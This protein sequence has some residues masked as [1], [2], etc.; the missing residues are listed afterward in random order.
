VAQRVRD[1]LL[2][3][4]G[5]S[6]DAESDLHQLA[7]ELQRF[8]GITA[9][10]D[11]DIQTAAAER[12]LKSATD[13]VKAFG[14][15]SEEAKVDLQTRAAQVKLDGL[16]RNLENLQKKE[17]SPKVDLAIGA[18]VAKIERVE[19]QLDKLDR[20]RVDIDIDVDR[21]GR[22]GGIAGAAVGAA[23]G[24]ASGISTAA[25]GL[26]EVVAAAT[27]GIP[28]LGNFASAFAQLGVSAA[29]LG[30]I[31][32]ILIPIIGVLLLNAVVL[33]SGAVIA[34]G[35]SFLTAAAGVG[36]LGLALAA[37][38][39]PVILVAIAAMARF[40]KILQAV[41]ASED[42]AAQS[43]QRVK[44][45]NEGLVVAQ[46]NAADAA[47]R[48]KTTAVDA[49][50]A[51]RDAAE[52][53]RDAIR[54]IGQAELSRDQ[55]HLNVKKAEQALRDVRKE[56][57][58]TGQEFDDLFSVKKFTDVDVS[59]EG[60]A[61]AISRAAPPGAGPAGGGV[62]QLDVQQKI[63][64]LRR[65]RLD[66]KDAIDG[67]SDAQTRAEDAR[68]REQEFIKNG[69]NAY[70]PYAAALQ[71]SADAMAA[72]AKS[73]GDVNDA[74]DKADPLKGLTKQERTLVGVLTRLKR[75]LTNLFRPATDAIFGGILDALKDLADFADDPRIKTAFTNLGRAIGGV[76]RSIGRELRRKE[77]RDAFVDFVNAGA[78]IIR[79]LV[80]VFRTVFRTLARVA[81]A[82]MPWLLEV[83]QS[84]ADAFRGIGRAA[85]RSKIKD[86]IDDIKESFDAWWQIAKDLWGIIKE[87][88][89]DARESG[90]KL[91]GH[92]HRILKDFRD[93]L[94]ENPD[95]IKEFFDKA[96][97]F[98]GKLVDSLPGI[99][100]NLKTI[101]GLAERISAAY[102][103]IKGSIDWI[104]KN[105]GPSGLD[106]LGKVPDSIKGPSLIDLLKGRLY[107]ATGGLIPGT[108]RGDIVPALLEPGEY[109]I[110]R[111]VVQ[112][113][114]LNRL[115]QLNAGHMPQ[116][117]QT[118]GLVTGRAGGHSTNIGKIVV[119]VPAGGLP[120][121][122]ATAV[123]LARV[124]EQRGGGPRQ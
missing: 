80:P 104:N 75:T 123:K 90:N 16:K 44:T 88:F 2:R 116:R 110:R 97:K 96:Q 64:D 62:D 4:R 77:T 84:I 18:T 65:A 43:A 22:A 113:V 6:S 8:D 46:R 82:A 49:Y 106:L 118:G 40:A 41:K 12:K 13:A 81:E 69:I 92:I 72:L 59:T 105:K 3:I 95:A 51:W 47:Q 78:T 25:Q 94:H 1:I 10:A 38:F 37:A 74:R 86:T 61:K 120:D 15:L 28:I 52:E 87:F 21:H 109:V 108:G 60:L 34:L 98:A 89:G 99:V 101:A 73:T 45:A 121:P 57:K 19:Q 71:A 5:D 14:R 32:L 107:R 58:L 26:G 35:A 91:A 111:S 30:P 122:T 39:G 76:F 112:A 54:G 56:A 63:L 67:V 114:G 103:K 85:T 23:G 29:A 36:V 93:W 50:R 83:V 48:V 102:D 53:T 17:T 119:E 20:R 70:E 117:M 33:L 66:E 7:R 124:L 9:T 100:E 31:F 42:G 79:K 55:A 27:R 11:V 115:N 24:I 68:K